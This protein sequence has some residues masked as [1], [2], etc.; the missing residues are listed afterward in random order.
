MVIVGSSVVVGKIIIVDFP[1]FLAS[2]LRFA[3]ASLIL[4]PLLLRQSRGIP[5]LSIKD[6]MIL[7]LQA[8]TG[9]FLFNIFLLYGLKFTTA[10]AGGIITSTTPAIVGI[11]AFFVLKERFSWYK[12]A[13]IALAVVGI[14]AVNLGTSSDA[15]HG[16][17]PALGNFM[18]F[19]AAIGEALFTIFRKVVS[20]KVTPLC[21][22]TVVSVFSLIMFAPW[23]ACESTSFDFSAITLE[24]WVLILY[25]GIGVTVVSFIL[26]FKGVSKVPASTAA[27]FTGVMPVS[28][29]AL[30]YVFLGE[31]LLWSHLVS[32]LSV[33]GGIV[34]IAR[35]QRS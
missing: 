23:A 3:I 11:I 6:W 12:S 17:N 21:N 13:G 4:V 28:A 16:S 2:G 5:S 35:G 1:V 14:L 9:V 15:E 25:Y 31:V 8:L 32:A 30:S 19:L 34:L 29:V 10:M 33:I 22:A 26:W 7:F 20:E 27:V 18:I 24:E